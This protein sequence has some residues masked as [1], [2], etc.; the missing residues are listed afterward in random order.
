MTSDPR[1][2]LALD[3]GAA[4]SS[5]ALIGR[6]AHR[7]RLIG[8]LALPAGVEV[9]ALI[10]LLLD[11]AA[12]ADP[13]L[14]R[15][16]GIDAGAAAAAGLP[17]LV[18][19][20]A[21][22]QRLVAVAASERALGPLATA[23]R[24]TGWRVT[25]ASPETTDPLALT[26][27]L[28]D[29]AVNAVLIGAGEPPGA[30]ER[31][32]LGDIVSL[33]AAAASRRPELAV[34]LAGSMAEQ[35]AS[36]EAL[37]SERQGEVL[38]A[39]AATAGDPAGEPL[40]ELLHDVRAPADDTRRSIAAGAAALADVLDRRVEVLEV[41]FDGGLRAAAAPG[42]AGARG[43]ATACY[44]AEAGL[45]PPDPDDAFVDR[46]L[47]W[48][49]L[50]LDR[51]RLRDRLRE[52]R[53]A[54]WADA[55]GDGA[56]LRLAALRAAL[57]AL[58]AATPAHLTEPAPDLL[59]VSGGSWAV[60]PGPA[61]A[62]AVADVVRRPAAI[63]VSFDHA[64]LLGSLGSI[65][66]A[67]E[68]RQAIGDLADDLL[69]PLASVVIPAGI[70]SGRSAGRA[71]VHGGAGAADVELLPGGLELV[72]LPPGEIATA[73]LHFRDTVR[74]G[75]RGRRFAVDL[76]GGLGGLLIDLRDI[77]LRLPERPERRREVLDAWQDSLWVTR[78]R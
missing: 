23:A 47:G 77:P 55:A 15:T 4:T 10:E 6:V 45:V 24:L 38:L 44:L 57:S 3:L 75:G 42:V 30:D 68:R 14:A 5:A 37:A 20:S 53:L 29:P 63:S 54:P 19:R 56:R 16:I 69:A 41:G 43:L 9:D 12:A 35:L 22:P 70:R 25:A 28:L 66:D 13:E 48:S 76:S 73:E 31:H 52:L 78:D 49:T 65:P 26:A 67:T 60:A 11:R 50:P 36:F 72:D 71:I 27:T 33:V 8:S 62:L 64:R 21:P 46:V 34:I 40:R 74:L 17:Q 7:W 61:I 39:P 2:F 59:V 32:A 18:A 58:V 51:H 1:A